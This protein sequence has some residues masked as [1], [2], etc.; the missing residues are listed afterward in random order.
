MI[1][2]ANMENDQ[3]ASLRNG[4]TRKTARMVSSRLRCI[5]VGSGKGGVGKTVVSIGLSLS[6]A[7]SGY[8][9]LILDADLGLANVDLQLGLDPK[10]TLQDVVF[11]QCSLSDAVMSVE[12]N[13]DMLPSSTGAPEMVEMGNARRQ[14][15]VDDLISFASEYDYLVIDVAAGIG[16]SITEFLS[17][18]PE[19]IVVVANEP[20]S[21]MDAYS[22]VKILLK[23]EEPPSIMMVVN[24]VRSLDEGETLVK[25]LNSVTDNFLGVQLPLAGTVL[26]DENVRN[27]V[28]SR[29]SVLSYA[30][31]SS[32]SQCIKEL[33]RYIVSGQHIA[34]KGI[35]KANG[36]FDKLA[37]NESMRTVET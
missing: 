36:I 8:R 11:G 33:A 21:V 13:L 19:V 15:L 35:R 26:F 22:L 20:T 4:D 25:R 16:R 29:E 32:S 3:A 30:P 10:Y 12:D 24:M 6:L 27:A 7:R 2:S 37:G 31:E 23:Q 28:R 14:L 5:S 17:A 1:M 18:S 34:G 9:V